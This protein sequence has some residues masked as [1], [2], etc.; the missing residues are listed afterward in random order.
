MK[1]HNRSV[2][3]RTSRQANTL[4]SGIVEA[5]VG[6]GL[7]QVDR[8]RLLSRALEPLPLACSDVNRICSLANHRHVAMGRRHSFSVFACFDGGEACTT[9]PGVAG[10]PQPEAPL[11][12]MTGRRKAQPI[13]LNQTAVRYSPLFSVTC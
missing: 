5:P 9:Y 10:Q 6:A 12:A 13:C 7:P 2:Q 11:S 8:L 4:R 3:N 1:Y